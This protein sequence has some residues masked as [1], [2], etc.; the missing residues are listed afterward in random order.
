MDCRCGV[1]WRCREAHLACRPTSTTGRPGSS[2]PCVRTTHIAQHRCRQAAAQTCAS[3]WK[4]SR[5]TAA[6]TSQPSAPALCAAPTTPTVACAKA[7][8]ERADD[9]EEREAAEEEEG[10][11]ELHHDVGAEELPEHVVDDA[12]ERAPAH[13]HAPSPQH[14]T[15]HAPVSNSEGAVPAAVTEVLAVALVARAVV[16]VVGAV[17]HDLVPRLPCRLP[18]QSPQRVVLPPPCSPIRTSA[19]TSVPACLATCDAARTRAVRIPG[20]SSWR[21]RPSSRRSLAPARTALHVSS[22]HRTALAARQR[23]RPG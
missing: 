2:M 6:H 17:V 9:A 22:T 21:G 11:S 7:A 4:F 12:R 8:R 13:H 18:V 23:P 20:G 14:R 1:A 16:V 10:K 5:I 15:E 3:S 19:P